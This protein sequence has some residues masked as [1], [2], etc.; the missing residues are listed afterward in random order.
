[1]IKMSEEKQAQPVQGLTSVEAARL[2]PGTE[3]RYIA[4]MCLR[5]QR[6]KRIHGDKIPPEQMATA[7]FGKRVGKYWYVPLSELNRVF[8]P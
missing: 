8:L 7:L 2:F 3:A 5:G 4:R 1:V 6:L